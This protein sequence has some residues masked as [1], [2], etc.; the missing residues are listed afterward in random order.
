MN[1]DKKLLLE[2]NAEE[3][4]GN[5]EE[6]LKRKK[7]VAY[8]GY[9]PSGEIHLGHLVTI[10]KLMDLIKAGVKVKVLFADWHAFLNRKGNW[11]FIKQQVTT[12]KRGFK[13]AGLK[14]AEFVV[15]TEYQKAENY[16]NDVLTLA[17]SITI[18][19]AVRSM[20]QVGRDMEHARVSQIIYPL[21]QITDMKYL[22][23]D[24]VVSGVDQ[25]KIHMLAIE[26]LEKI[27]FKVPL[28]I[29]TPIIPSLQGPG[30]KMSSS[31]PESMVSI[32]DSSEEL[33]KKI[34]KAYC[35]EGVVEDNP[36][37]S[38]AKLIIFPRKN[39]LRIKRAAKYGG[40]IELNSY[41][42]LETMFMDKKIH[43]LDLKNSVF[44][45]LNEITETMRREF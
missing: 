44:E 39:K 4:I 6:V 36:I 45:E 23:V 42:Q 31:S 32:R 18:N 17:Q 24:I 33:K 10:T 40:D 21:M 41:E 11:D 29:H 30:S 8:C 1:K 3:V 9:E 15:G 25:R 20:Q 16:I 2:N 26:T 7:I 43:P 5:I 38:I 34:T 27:G 14:E 35:P 28:F 19:R 22:D 37:L 12:W 13:A